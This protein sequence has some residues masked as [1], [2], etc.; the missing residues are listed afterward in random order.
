VPALVDPNGKLGNYTV[1]SSN[2]V[3][4]VTPAPLSVA[5]ANTSRAYGDPNPIFAGTITGIK[6]ADNITATYASVALV[7]SPVGTFGIV[8]TLI[9]P[10]TKLGNYTVS[11]ING[12]L[13]VAP[14][15]L[16]VA[17]TNASRL[18]GDPNP[19]FTGTITGIKNAD[20]ITATFASAAL[21]TSPVGTFPIVGTLAD[22]GSKL[23]N[24]AVTSNSGTLTVNPAALSASAA[25][26]TRVYGD[27]NPVF[28][29]AITGLKNGDVI[30]LTFSSAGPASP[31]GTFAIVPA[32]VDPGLKAGNY[33]V[34]KTNGTL[35]VTVAPLSVTAANASRAYGDPNPLFNGSI[36]G[37]KNGDSISATFSTTAV[38]ASLIGTYPIIP[39]L[40]DPTAK[41]G[42]YS[43]TSIN[44]VLTVGQATPAVTI[45][46][47]PGQPTTT[48]LVRV[49]NAGAVLPTGT[50]QFF[51]GAT[52]LGLPVA[53]VPPTP[54]AA[55]EASITASL[56]AGNHAISVAY[57]GDATYK[58]VTTPVVTVTVGPAPAFGLS[59]G[60]GGNTSATIQAGQNATFNL[61]LNPQG[62]TG[63]IT[64]ACSGAP[65]GTTC[66]VSPGSVSVNAAS[67]NVPITV[68]VSGTQNASAVP[69]GF[70]G[71]TLFTF[72]GV[73]AGV[74]LGIRRK[75]KQVVLMLLA[76]GLIASLSACGGKATSSSPT[77]RPPTTAT[78]V[79]TGTSGSQSASINLSLTINH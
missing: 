25:D 41:L 58:A 73:F 21:I 33:S 66:N 22:P 59:A 28:T 78:I 65:A 76:M 8:P 43:V 38:P 4:T 16:T 50:V 26:A 57:A 35:T 2:G 53:I 64:L 19:S 62:F 74:L 32:L 27:P 11:S 45:T 12:T 68:T 10:T 44:G 75:R 9:D 6:N 71:M 30:T 55:P 69:A 49:Q 34:T 37:I 31:I 67:A 61:A 51:D 24:Y 1:T 60:T 72:A 23:G 39:A 20:N 29:G 56:A 7:T 47:Q 54:G 63:T 48:L 18:Y 13:T 17:G 42:N 5:A 46:A 36:V 77:V 70:K 79:V 15:V 40:V 3:L 14:A 52:A